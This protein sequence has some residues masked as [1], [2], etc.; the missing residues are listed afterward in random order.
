[1]QGPPPLDEKVGKMGK[2]HP[3]GSSASEDGAGPR[4]LQDRSPP[5]GAPAVCV[6]W[7]VQGAALKIC[8]VPIQGSPTA[9]LLEENECVSGGLAHFAEVL[10]YF[11]NIVGCRLLTSCWLF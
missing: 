5:A 6:G 1:M 10:Q 11:L 8:R 4:P 3:H 7:R 2:A 9:R